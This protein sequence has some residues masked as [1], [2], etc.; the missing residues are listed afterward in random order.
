MVMGAYMQES[1]KNPWADEDLCFFSEAVLSAQNLHFA[2]KQPFQ[3]Y[4]NEA[5]YCDVVKT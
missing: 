3:E 5:P 1:L 2:L 4:S